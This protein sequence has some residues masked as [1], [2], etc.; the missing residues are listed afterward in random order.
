V[1]GQVVGL[2]ALDQILRFFLRGVWVD[3][4]VHDAWVR[5]H[6]CVVSNVE[7]SSSCVLPD[8]ERLSTFS[9]SKKENR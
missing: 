9:A 8:M 6:V 4:M 7:A 3:G 5:Q 2:L 1:H